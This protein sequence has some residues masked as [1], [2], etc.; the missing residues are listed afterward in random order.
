MN[1]IIRFLIKIATVIALS[2]VLPMLW[3]GFGNPIVDTPMDAVKVAL[4]LSILNTFVKPILQFFALPIT[5]LTMGLFSL[6]IS[7]AIV[8]MAQQLVTGFH[9]GGWIAALLFSLS[10]SF[11]SATV[12]R[13]IVE[14]D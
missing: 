6:V 7:A 8:L 2:Y 11:V 9:V 12:E 4:V 3:T 1:F 10:F 13:L 14:E 5:C